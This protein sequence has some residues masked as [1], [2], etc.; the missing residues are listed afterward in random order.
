NIK[1]MEHKP[2]ETDERSSAPLSDDGEQHAIQS[3]SVTITEQNKG[4]AISKCVDS[5]IINET[6]MDNQQKKHTALGFTPS[7]SPLESHSNSSSNSD[8]EVRIM[9]ILGRLRILDEILSDSDDSSAEYTS[10]EFDAQ[11]IDMELLAISLEGLSIFPILPQREHERKER[12]ESAIGNE[13]IA[14]QSVQ[15]GTFISND[16]N[17]GNS[18]D[19]S[20]DES[21]DSW[22]CL[23]SQDLV[24]MLAPVNTWLIEAQFR[25]FEESCDSQ[26]ESS[27]SFEWQ[28]TLSSSS[29]S[30]S[31][32]SILSTAPARCMVNSKKNV[33]YIDPSCLT[34]KPPKHGAQARKAVKP[35]MKKRQSRHG[36]K[37]SHSLATKN[38][39]GNDEPLRKSHRIDDVRI[40][41]SKMA[42]FL[43]RPADAGE[44]VEH[45]EV[46][47]KI[48]RS[49]RIQVLT[50]STPATTK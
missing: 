44:V 28:N 10:E 1:K 23:L 43:K 32:R 4:F 13:S 49:E 35:S 24:S 17:D 48:R 47:N 39:S 16:Y 11:Q 30:S 5:D 6:L 38:S 3:I 36:V 33:Q 26:S 31:Y 19:L 20:E 50:N 12:S 15:P 22:S 34:E 37:R 7:S 18:T 2:N 45:S 40:P 8:I 42:P 41:S 9:S 25:E 14:P 21:Q 29:S 27:C 46:L